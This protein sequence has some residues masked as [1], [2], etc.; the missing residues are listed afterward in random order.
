MT[1]RLVSIGRDGVLRLAMEGSVRGSD[2]N[3]VQPHPMAK[4]AGEGWA[5]NRIAL[6]M[7]GVSYLDSSAIGWLLL[8]HRE[9]RKQGGLLAIHSVAPAVRQMLEL[10]QLQQVLH[11]AADEAAAVALAQQEVPA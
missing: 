1:L 8:C 5:A 3:D 6:D 9:C 4:V 7:A 10:L 11:V 2:V